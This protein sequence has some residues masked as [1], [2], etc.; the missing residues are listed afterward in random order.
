[1]RSFIC[2]P[3]ITYEGIECT[4]ASLELLHHHFQG[5]TPLFCF[6]HGLIFHMWSYNMFFC[7]LNILHHIPTEN[8]MREWEKQNIF[9]KERT[10]CLFQTLYECFLSCESSMQFAC[11]SIQ[12]KVFDF[13][14]Y[15][16]TNLNIYV[17]SLAHYVHNSID[18]SS[19]YYVKLKNTKQ[20]LQY[21]LVLLS[22][23]FQIHMNWHGQTNANIKCDTKVC[24]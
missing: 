23:S 2:L 11:C 13:D 12:Q 19:K 9:W 5:S 21:F 3:I 18:F 16:C 14:G 20:M 24:D 10:S 7:L 6:S 15:C 17:S 22:L 8:Q 1:M 4:S